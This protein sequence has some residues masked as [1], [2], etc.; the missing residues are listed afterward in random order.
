MM[1]LPELNHNKNL[2]NLFFPNF[3]DE[4]RVNFSHMTEFHVS[5][6]CLFEM[7]SAQDR[8]LKSASRPKSAGR[9]R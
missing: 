8:R 1:S 3:L 4:P 2:L 7:Q 5:D 6:T 9:F